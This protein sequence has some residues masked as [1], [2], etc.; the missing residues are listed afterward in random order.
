C[1]PV[2]QA[3]SCWES[4]GL[5]GDVLSRNPDRLPGAFSLRKYVHNA[6]LLTANGGEQWKTRGKRRPYFGQPSG[7][8]FFCNDRFTAPFQ[9]PLILRIVGFGPDFADGCGGDLLDFTFG[10]SFLFRL[11]FHSPRFF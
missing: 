1:E 7:G 11:C 2:A 8:F 5:P 6:I 4:G 3:L 9:S 10:I